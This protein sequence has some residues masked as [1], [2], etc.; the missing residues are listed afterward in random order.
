M[1]VIPVFGRLGQE[2]GKFQASGGHVTTNIQA[3]KEMVNRIKRQPRVVATSA[4]QA[5]DER[6]CKRVKETPT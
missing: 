1:P 5:S 6:L 3:S 4:C 2:D